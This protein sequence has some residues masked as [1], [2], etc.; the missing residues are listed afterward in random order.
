MTTRCDEPYGADCG[1][2]QSLRD[3]P[4]TSC[5]G[6]CGFTYQ[7]HS[8]CARCCNVRTDAPDP[9]GQIVDLDRSHRVVE[10]IRLAGAVEAL[11]VFVRGGAAPRGVAAAEILAAIS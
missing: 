9:C 6:D 10:D 5:D 7:R 11:R 4:D 1:H 2:T 8:T 3:T